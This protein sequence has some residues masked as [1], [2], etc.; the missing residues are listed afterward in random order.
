VHALAV[1]T[2]KRIAYRSVRDSAD[3]GDSGKEKSSGNGKC[4]VV[5]VFKQVS[6]H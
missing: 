5:T 1:L 6:R 3:F 2:P 4:K